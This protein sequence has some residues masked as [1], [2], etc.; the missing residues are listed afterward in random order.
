RFVFEVEGFGFIS[1]D[2][3]AQMNGMEADHHYRIQ[4]SCYYAL[5]LS[6][7]DGHVY[8]PKEKCLT[9]MRTILKTPDVTDE[10]MLQQINIL[11]EEKRIIELNGNL[12]EPTLYY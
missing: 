7:E 10:F 8:L 12:Y 1:A 4:A 3:I 11:I 6:A 5:Q 2:K 9:E